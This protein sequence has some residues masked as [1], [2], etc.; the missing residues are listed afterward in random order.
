MK[1]AFL[2]AFA[3]LLPFC[4]SAQCSE[5][6]LGTL[7][8]IE[9]TPPHEKE[10]KILDLGFDLTKETGSGATNTRH[11]EKCWETTDKGQAMYQ[12]IIL[13]RT[14]ANDITFLTL[15]QNVHQKIKNAINEK[16]QN[17]G[18]SQVVLG[19]MFRYSFNTQYINGYTYYAVTLAMR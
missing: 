7:Q 4:L 19:K 14:N 11:Y 16:H 9:K 10:N 3:A 2:L 1:S 8:V 5:M 17:D 15:H 6:T 12:Q 13:W 18:G